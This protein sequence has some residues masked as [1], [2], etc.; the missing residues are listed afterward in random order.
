M[1][2]GVYSVFSSES[3]YNLAYELNY[4]GQTSCAR[5]WVIYSFYQTPDLAEIFP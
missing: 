1:Q 5:A 2:A 3:L 4:F